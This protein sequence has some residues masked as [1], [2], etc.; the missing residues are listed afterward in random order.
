MKFQNGAIWQLIVGLLGIT[1]RASLTHAAEFNYSGRLSPND[2]LF[3]SQEQHGDSI[4]DNAKPIDLSASIGVGS[5]CGK[6][7]FQATLQSTL[8]QI[9]KGGFFGDIGKDI[10]GKAPMLAICYMSPTWCAIVKHG[11][12]TA[13]MLSQ[14]RL[15][16][17]SIIDKY[18][19]SRVEDYYHE[20]QSCV[21]RAIEANGGNMD[22]AME[23]CNKDNA[24]STELTNWAGSKYGDK[25]TTNKLIDSSAR[26]AGLKNQ[27]SQETLNLVKSLVG[28]TVLANGSLSVEYGPRASPM[29][30]RTYLQSIERTTYDKLC[31]RI[32]SK[33]DQ[34]GSALPVDQTISDTDLK[35][36]N[37]NA[38][39][40]SI[41]R[42]TIRALAAM[43]PKQRGMACK[44]LSDATAMTLFSND[45]NRS[46]D[47]LTTLSQNPNLPPQRKQEIEEKR[48]A[49]K[50]QIEMTVELQRERSEPLNQVL[51][52]I[53]EEGSR[54]QEEEV[55]EVLNAEFNS[56]SNHQA[57]LNW[58]DCSDGVMCN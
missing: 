48:R 19:D 10:L 17:C 45:V 25:V 23:N 16:Q 1:L 11:Q 42:S 56:E 31:N 51:A 30:P 6:I 26:W 2:Y 33:M 58:T 52:Q 29:T 34:A 21:H 46:L 9:I 43:S 36:L 38:A 15:N 50:E 14:L 49:L 27:E 18:V 28:D 32:L 12:L 7:N 54:L 20:R 22:A 39:Q 47:V 41:D 40:A 35:D 13:N 4:F 5:D 8:D 53:H 57:N 55:G 37:K 3:G 24:W 44:K